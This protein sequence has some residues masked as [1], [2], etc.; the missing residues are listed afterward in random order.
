MRHQTSLN[1]AT[2]LSVSSVAQ[3]QA[4]AQQTNPSLN[5][6]SHRLPT[7]KRPLPL[8]IFLNPISDPIPLLPI[9]LSSLTTPCFYLTASFTMGRFG[10][11]LFIALLVLLCGSVQVRS[12]GSDH[13]Y[14]DGDSVPLY[15]NKVGP[16][17]NPR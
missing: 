1:D 8:I 10:A 4:Q 2:S 17:H 7:L 11:V 13:R 9:S 6:T 5:P 16:F 12:D 15:A 3:A 14:K